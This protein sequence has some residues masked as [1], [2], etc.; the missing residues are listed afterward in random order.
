[1][2]TLLLPESLILTI[3]SPQLGTLEVEAEDWYISVN[4]AFTAV[5]QLS[6]ISVRC[7][8]VLSPR[9]S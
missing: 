6:W 1:M 3:L 4:P 9:G 8:P 5:C 7:K 2:T